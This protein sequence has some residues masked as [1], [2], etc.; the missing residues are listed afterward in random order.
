M[1]DV[2]DI[3]GNRVA[4]E[5]ASEKYVDEYAGHT[6][7]ARTGSSLFPVEEELLRPL[8]ADRPH[9]VH[10]QSGWGLDDVALIKEGASA[11]TAVD[12]SE[13]AARTSQRRAGELGVPCRYVVGSLPGAPLAGGCADL[14]YTGKGGLIWMPDI[15]AWAA[16][17]VRLL[18]PGGHLFVFDGHPAFALWSWDRDKARIRPDRSYFARSYANDSFPANGA[19]E[20]QWTL[21]RLVTA[22]VTAGLEIRHLGEHPEPFWKDGD[23]DLPIHDGR[24]PNTFSLL[25]RKRR[26]SKA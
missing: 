8:L 22:V 20:F 17:I 14:V 19:I 2:D 12:F 11:V 9:V 21:G 16:D 10:L 24:L 25:A 23:V 3:R 6:A 13:V 15:D 5:K 26:D 18:R 4:W 7:L 1:P